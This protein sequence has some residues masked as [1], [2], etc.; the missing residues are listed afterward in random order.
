L[1]ILRDKSNKF[2]YLVNCVLLGCPL[3]KEMLELNYTHTIP[4]GAMTD[5]AISNPQFLVR[6]PRGKKMHDDLDIY[7]EKDHCP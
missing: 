7:T 5:S 2:Y 4:I 1:S 3:R 6:M